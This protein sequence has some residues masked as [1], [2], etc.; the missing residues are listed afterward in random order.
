MMYV[1]RNLSLINDSFDQ[2]LTLLSQI[3]YFINYLELSYLIQLQG[4]LGLSP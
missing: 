3:P 2:D 1:S 4:M